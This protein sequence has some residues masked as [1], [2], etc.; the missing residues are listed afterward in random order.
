MK[1]LVA[2]AAGAVGNMLVKELYEGGHQVVGLVHSD[3]KTAKVEGAGGSPIIADVTDKATLID[4]VSGADVVVFAA[5]SGGSAVEQVDRDGAI[6]LVDVAQ[7]AGV[8]RFVMLSSMAAGEPDRG[9]E[10]LRDYLV[11]KGEADHYLR[12]SSLSH[13]I[14]RPGSLTDDAGSGRIRIA[15]EKLPS[16][17]IARADVAKVLAACVEDNAP[18]DITFELLSG[19]QPIGAALASVAG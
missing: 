13:V 16:G 18:Q 4:P 9:P 8:A 17:E 11:A 3:D 1:I 7:Q 14:V 5:G 19:E 6:N 10:E 12:D 2:G 15:T